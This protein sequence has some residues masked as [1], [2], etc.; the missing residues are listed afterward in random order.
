MTYDTPDT[1]NVKDSE[2]S[3]FRG[4]PCSYVPSGVELVITPNF[5]EDYVLM[6][7]QLS[8]NGA[9]SVKITVRS[10]RGRRFPLIAKE[11]VSSYVL[12]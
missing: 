9:D 6:V 4:G 1:F 7:L 12:C 10:N 11:T 8:V 3:I 2:P 5:V